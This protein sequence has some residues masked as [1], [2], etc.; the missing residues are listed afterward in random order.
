MPRRILTPAGAVFCALSGI[1]ALA[2]LGSP[3][4]ATVFN[5]SIT[6]ADTASLSL[7]TTDT[8]SPFL[9]TGINGTFDGSNIMGPLPVSTGFGAPDNLIHE[10][11]PFLDDN[12]LSFSTD[13]GA[14]VNVFFNDPNYIVDV[15]GGSHL[16]LVNFAVTSVP[17]PA[18]LT[19]LGTALIGF[20]SFKL[21]RSRRD[22]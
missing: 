7:T 15:E 10:P 8:S 1:A 16:D 9:I 6:G 14:D 20:V 11:A 22:V 5:F 3:A 4:Q 13:S 18:S 2:L 21:R 17:E 12:G 19:L